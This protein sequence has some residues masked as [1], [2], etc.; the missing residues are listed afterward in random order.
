MR[1]LLLGHPV[2]HSASPAMQNAAFAAMGLPHLYEAIDVEPEAI[3]TAV[4]DV[5]RDDCLGANVTVPYK[6]AVRAFLDGL[7]PGAELTD[8]VNT[9]VKSDGRL[10]G[11]NTDVEGAWEGLLQPVADA[12]GGARV[13][14]AGAGGGARAVISA[15]ERALHRAPGLV[16]VVARDVGRAAEVAELGT[17]R[18]LPTATAPWSEMVQACEGAT[19]VINCTPLGL[20]GEDPF[21]G[22]A[23]SQR[24]VLDLA[25]APGGTPL[26]R[27]ARAEGASSTLQGDQML[28]HQGA[29]AFRLWTGMDAPLEVMRA[30]LRRAMT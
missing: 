16:V 20:H 14:V 5:R 25:Y 23:L 13:V 29:A 9:I 11:H 12:L 30:E 18:G 26:V 8:A 3:A 7:D 22:V 19:V 10:T 15:L 6:I 24:C 27:R 28:L 1:V 21:E 2:A 4:D 17:R